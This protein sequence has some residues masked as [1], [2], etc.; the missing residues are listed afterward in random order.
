MPY[1]SPPPIW[2]PGKEALERIKSAD[3]CSESGAIEQL[4]A[5]VLDRAVPI[6]FP[7]RSRPKLP[8]RHPLRNFFPETGPG[9][10]PMLSVDWRALLMPSAQFRADGMVKFHKASWQPFE[11]RRDAVLRY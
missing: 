7:G 5:A 1:V 4:T 8:E 9:A 11:V 3:K 2:M 6:R 10:S